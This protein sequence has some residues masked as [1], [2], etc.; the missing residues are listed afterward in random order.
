MDRSGIF[1][2]AVAIIGFILGLG[3]F[4]YG[5]VGQYLGWL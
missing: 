3:L 4:L 1:L 2:I 5:I